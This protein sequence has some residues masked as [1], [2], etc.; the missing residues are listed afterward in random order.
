MIIDV[1]TCRNEHR[2]GRVFAIVTARDGS[3]WEYELLAAADGEFCRE[4]L[5]RGTIRSELWRQVVDA[6]AAP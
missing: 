1:A 2:D 3:L 6:G 5:K 4:I